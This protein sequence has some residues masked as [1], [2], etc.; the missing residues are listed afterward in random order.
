MEKAGTSDDEVEIDNEITLGEL[1]ELMARKYNITEL[2]N[3]PNSQE[4]AVLVNGTQADDVK[5]RLSDGDEVVILPALAG[6][7]S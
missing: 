4:V 7:C 1:L 6:G 2:L 3:F 5:K